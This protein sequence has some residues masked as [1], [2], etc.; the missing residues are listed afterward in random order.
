MA[1][2][3]V[4]YDQEGL[5]YLMNKGRPVPGQSLTSDPN[6][7]RPWEKPPRFT[8]VEPALD[9]LFVELTEPEVYD[10]LMN[11]LREGLPIGDL[12]QVILKDGFE[13]GLWN[14]DLMLLLIEPV[15]YILVA[16]AEK[17]KVEYKLYAGED[18]EL[19]SSEEQ[20]TGLNKAMKVAGE[21]IVPNLQE[22]K[23]PP[24]YLEELKNLDLSEKPSLLEAGETPPVPEEGLLTRREV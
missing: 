21:K 20:L 16:L 4:Q 11:I 13:K 6:A 3:P 12:T 17:A 9:Y 5:D 14:P 18:E 19:S 8:E 10:S 22:G 15:M 2:K 24:Q 7:P 23:I 1:T